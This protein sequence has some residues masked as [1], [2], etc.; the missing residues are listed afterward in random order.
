[1]KNGFITLLGIFLAIHLF[2]QCHASG[3]KL[4]WEGE[5][6]HENH[7]FLNVDTNA[8][9]KDD[10]CHSKELS[11]KVAKSFSQVVLVNDDDLIL[12]WLRSDDKDAYRNFLQMHVCTL[13]VLVKLGEFELLKSKMYNDKCLEIGND[14]KTLLGVAAY[15]GSL[16]FLQLLFTHKKVNALYCDR[17]G[18]R[19]LEYAREGL[20][21]YMQSYPWDPTKTNKCNEYKDCIEFLEKKESEA[22]EREKKREKS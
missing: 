4:D 19:P 5:Y 7:L 16:K 9:K 3:F 12:H 18:K 11:S 10:F 17:N 20:R 21:D 22:H 13:S 15:R 6:A 8:L 14:G 2:Y 1:M